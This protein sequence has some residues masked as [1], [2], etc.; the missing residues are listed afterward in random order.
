MVEKQACA[1]D[2]LVL[3][4][5]YLHFFHGLPGEGG[6]KSIHGVSWNRLRLPSDLSTLTI[7]P[8]SLFFL[9]QYSERGCGDEGFQ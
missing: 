6:Y 2:G 9:R 7:E 8:N 1:A 3:S 4:L 5:F